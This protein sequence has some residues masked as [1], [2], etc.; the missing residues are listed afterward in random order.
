MKTPPPSVPDD[1]Q[2]LAFI[3]FRNNRPFQMWDELRGDWINIRALKPDESETGFCFRKTTIIRPM[4]PLG[5]RPWKPAEV[6]VGALI[7]QHGW[8]ASRSVI[9]GVT[10]NGWISY[11]C[12]NTI[13]EVSVG[14]AFR[15]CTHSIDNGKTWLPCSVNA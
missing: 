13:T 8:P 6:P 14:T 2:A 9:I 12:V 4:P 1:E 5:G 10:G 3:D 11:Y 15:Q 7:R